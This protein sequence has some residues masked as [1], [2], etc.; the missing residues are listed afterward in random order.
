MSK[1]V[2]KPHRRWTEAELAELR[3]IY[4]A[5]KAGGP[6]NL[7]RF[8]ARYGRQPGNV[9]RKARELGLTNP[10]RPK[11]AQP[12]LPLAGFRQGSPELRAHLARKT[13]E[14]FAE[15]GH[16]RGMAGKKHR[17]ESLAKTREGNRRYWESITPAQLADRNRRMIATRIARHGSGNPATK[18]QHLHSLAKRGR[19]ADL[20]GLFV[21][22]AWEANIARWLNYLNT[23]GLVREWQYEPRTFAFADV[24]DAPRTY[25]PDF[26]VID[27]GGQEYFVE[28]KGRLTD[29]DWLKEE[30]LRACYP[31]IQLTRIDA[32]L[33]A[34]LDQCF[35][36]VLPHWERAS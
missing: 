30:R 35:R 8:A 12:R 18:G 25:T 36:D 31:G 28:V 29:L 21:G 7:D 22:S 32:S 17:P 20:G 33:Y 4:E 26:R 23:A 14:Q 16:P 11:T 19:R 34:E 24:T 9:D 2:Q 10:R 1:H 5:A 15:L 27:A 13:R 3:A 6:L